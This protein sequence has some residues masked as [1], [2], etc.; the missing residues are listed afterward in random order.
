MPCP[1]KFVPKPSPELSYILG[2]LD[3][4]GY[5][6]VMGRHYLVGLSS[7]D[8]EFVETFNNA[9]VKIFGKNKPYAIWVEKRAPPRK[10]SYGVKGVCKRFVIWYLSTSKKERWMLAKEYPKHYLRGI[11]DSEGSV[12]VQESYTS[13]APALDCRIV[14]YN[15]DLELL[16]FVQKLLAEQGYESKIYKVYDAVGYAKFPEGYFPRRKAEYALTITKRENVKRFANEI[17]FTIRRKQ[18]RLQRYVTLYETYGAG[19]RAIMEW[20]RMKT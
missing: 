19:I 17:G 1:C 12:I 2:V 15:T 16:M 13:N 5:V 9:L 3:G 4:D 14:L 18:E 10:P 6:R 8:K 11:F 20:R 7:I